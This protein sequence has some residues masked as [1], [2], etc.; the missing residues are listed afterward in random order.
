[1]LMPTILI[2]KVLYG[3]LAQGSNITKREKIKKGY[4][5]FCK[6]VCVCVCVCAHFILNKRQ[7]RLKEYMTKMFICS[8]TGQSALI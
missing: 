7:K 2:V 8:I 4:E 5:Y 1:M 6:A 3:S